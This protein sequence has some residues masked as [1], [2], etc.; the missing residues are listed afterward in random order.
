MPAL[1]T[2]RYSAT[3]ADCGAHLPAGT[4]AQYYG[5]GL[6]Y[7]REGCHDDPWAQSTGHV[8]SESSVPVPGYHPLDAASDRTGAGLVTVDEFRRRVVTRLAEV[9][10]GFYPEIEHLLSGDPGRTSCSQL[11]EEVDELGWGTSPQAF[12]VLATTTSQVA[13]LIEWHDHDGDRTSIAVSLRDDVSEP[14]SIAAIFQAATQVSASQHTL[15]C[16]HTQTDKRLHVALRNCLAPGLTHSQLNLSTQPQLRWENTI[17]PEF[18]DDVE[19]VIWHR[20]PLTLLKGDE[21]HDSFEFADMKIRVRWHHPD[22]GPI[23][24]HVSVLN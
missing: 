16:R 24:G 2:L 10:P 8:T 5:R 15:R 1:I 7:G 9:G 22:F 19:S 23:T 21:E 3:C 11:A 13:S 6:A 20:R 12:E 4:L 18:K 17:A 14:E